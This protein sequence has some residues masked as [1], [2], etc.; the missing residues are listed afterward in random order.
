M[1]I[2]SGPNRHPK[3]VPFVS[4]GAGRTK[5]FGRLGAYAHKEPQLLTKC[6]LSALQNYTFQRHSPGGDTRIDVLIYS[7]PQLPECLMKLLT[8]LHSLRA[9][10]AVCP[11]R[12]YK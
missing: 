11:P 4:F 6:Q 12:V 3:D 1:G 8:Y 5:R 2:I 7:A 9:Y 10:I